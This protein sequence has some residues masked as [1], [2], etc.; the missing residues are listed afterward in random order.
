MGWDGYYRQELQPAGVYV[1]K[2][3][4]RFADSRP[5]VNSRD[6]TLLWQYP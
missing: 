6:V 2:V 5:I 4:A 1:W 3:R